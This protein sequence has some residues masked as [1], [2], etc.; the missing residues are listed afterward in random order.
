VLV[1]HLGASHLQLKSLGKFRIFDENRDESLVVLD[2]KA[3]FVA[4]VL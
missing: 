3:D 4:D 2:G 1:D